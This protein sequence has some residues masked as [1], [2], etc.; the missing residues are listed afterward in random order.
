MA[1]YALLDDDN[2]VVQVITGKDESEGDYDWELV[3]TQSTGFQAKRTCVDTLGGAHVNGGVPF[4]KNYANVGFT[5]DRD[6]DAFIPPQ[7]FAS[8]TLNESTCQWDPPTP[9]PNDD[10]RYGWDEATISWI[11]ITAQPA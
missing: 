5:Y 1:Y 2:L 6:R 8:W 3:Y 10:K 9:R 7:P 4:R 11:E